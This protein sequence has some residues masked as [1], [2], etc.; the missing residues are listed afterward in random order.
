MLNIPSAW[1]ETLAHVQTVFP[2]AMIAG[3]A[4]RDLD[5]GRPIKDIDIFAPNCPT[6]FD[7][8]LELVRKLLPAPNMLHN[9]LGSYGTW[10][11]AE[12]VGVFDIRAPALDYQLICLSSPQ[13]SILPRIDFGLCRIGFDGRKVTR[14]PEYF[15]DQASQKFTLLRCEDSNQ[16]DRSRRRWER[17]TKKYQGW[18][19]HASDDLPI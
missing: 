3:G 9:M 17:F 13:S 2:E 7:E 11:T 5:N 14:T 15:E 12:C 19:L 10:A 8:T 4:L 6:S 16:L 1:A 18:A